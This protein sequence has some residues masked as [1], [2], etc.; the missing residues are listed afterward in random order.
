MTYKLTW[1]KDEGKYSAGGEIAL[2]GKWRIGS[3][4]YNGAGS[5]DNPLKYLANVDLPG[6]KPTFGPYM[7][8]EEAKAK[9]EEVIKYWFDKA[10]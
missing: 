2:V 3:A 10:Q 6:V 1:V 4:G 8:Q 9:V 5:R 7:T